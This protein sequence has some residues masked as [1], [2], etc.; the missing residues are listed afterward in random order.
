[1]VTTALKSFSW[2]EGMVRAVCEMDRDFPGY[3]LTQSMAERQMMVVILRAHDRRS[4][5]KMALAELGR[6]IRM[7]NKK[8]LLRKSIPGC[9]EGLTGAMGKIGWRVMAS[10]RYDDLIDLLREPAAAKVLC[11]IGR[12][13]PRII[14]NLKQLDP[15]YRNNTIVANLCSDDD[16]SELRYAVAVA[17]RFQP[18]ATD[19]ELARSLVQYYRKHPPEHPGWRTGSLGEWLGRRLRKFGVPTPPWEGTDVIVPLKTVTEIHH[20]AAEFRNCI[21]DKVASVVVGSRCFYV[22]RGKVKAVIALDHD[23]AMGWGVGEI[24][25]KENRQVAG[26]IDNEIR[27]SFGKAGFGEYKGWEMLGLDW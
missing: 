27:T 13:K 23:P 25:G 24:L 18:A 16:I 15:A 19:R 8:A 2:C 26:H 21:A 10:D 3:L 14:S 17:R 11:H 6:R 5:R 7:D 12:I 4:G 1:M 20:A 9:P 22:Y